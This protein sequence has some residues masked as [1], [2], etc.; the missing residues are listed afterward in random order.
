ML[1]KIVTR[2][3]FHRII[4]FIMFSLKQNRKGATSFNEHTMQTSFIKLLKH[5]RLRSIHSVQPL[6]VFRQGI[7]MFGN[8]RKL[9]D[10]CPEFEI[11]SRWDVFLF[12]K[13]Y[14]LIVFIKI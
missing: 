10:I 9:H 7:S 14:R 3:C 13:Q 6:P 1:K 4:V 12:H 8:P 11:I 5:K 2:S